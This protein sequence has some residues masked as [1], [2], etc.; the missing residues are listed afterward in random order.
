MFGAKYFQT[1]DWESTWSPSGVGWYRLTYTYSN[2]Y[3]ARG[4]APEASAPSRE[5]RWYPNERTPLSF[6]GRVRRKLR[7]QCPGER[8]R[9]GRCVFEHIEPVQRRAQHVARIAQL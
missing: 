7:G 1:I 9:W 3:G 8:Q 2:G 5:S 4:L 6:V